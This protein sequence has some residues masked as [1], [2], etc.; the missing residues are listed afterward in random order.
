MKYAVAFA[1]VILCG[2]AQQR[3][4]KCDVSHGEKPTITYSFEGL[5]DVEQKS[6]IDAF[7]AW[8]AV[9]GN[10]YSLSEQ[11]TGATIKICKGVLNEW[12]DADGRKQHELGRY[13]APDKIT[14]NSK[15][16]FHSGQPF[17]VDVEKM[18][19]DLDGLALHEVGH[20]FGLQH[21]ANASDVMWPNLH[22][23]SHFL[24][25]GDRAA[26][27]ALYAPRVH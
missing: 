27:R 20:F 21:S 9:I 15:F 6:F 24:H 26:I 10:K 16:S 13:T 18:E 23:E 14:I 22:V 1:L 3:Q 12:S 25:D 5:N 19:V 2:C 17:G 7:A 11:S 8:N 4:R